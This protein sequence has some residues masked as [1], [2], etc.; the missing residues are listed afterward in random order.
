M[1]DA[2]HA[3]ATAKFGHGAFDEAERAIAEMESA[4]QSIGAVIFK[5]RARW[6]QAKVRGARGE[7]EARAT[8]LREAKE[9]FRELGAMG[10]ARTVEK[11]LE[12][13]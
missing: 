12:A 5:P 13:I 9:G 7:N 3:M 2:L 1:P 8:L 4:A 11:E 6:L 10:H